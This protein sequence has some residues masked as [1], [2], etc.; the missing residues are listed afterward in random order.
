MFP[1]YLATR[2]VSSHIKGCA[3]ANLHPT[4]DRGQITDHCQPQMHTVGRTVST[5]SPSMYIGVIGDTAEV[6]R[7]VY[8]GMERVLGCVIGGRTRCGGRVLLLK[9]R[10]GTAWGG[11]DEG[12]GW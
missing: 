8:T 3:D 11:L 1:P 10:R 7:A 2:T 6:R 4:D 9:E 12:V 5:L